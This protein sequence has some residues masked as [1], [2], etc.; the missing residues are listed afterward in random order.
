MATF[1]T[2]TNLI[3]GRL[4]EVQLTSSTFSSATGMQ[5][6]MQNAVNAAIY[7]ICRR[8]QQWPFIY[9]QQT[10]TTVIGTQSYTPP[11]NCQAIKWNTFGIVRN[12]NASPPIVAATL[13]EMDYNLWATRRRFLD[14]QLT[15]TNYSTPTNVIKG[16]DGSI[17]LSPPPKQVMNITYDAWA[18]PTG[19]VN[20]NDSCVIPDS[21]N[22]IITDGA[23]W[24]GYDFRGDKA[25]KDDAENKFNSGVKEMQRLLIKPTNAFQS[26]MVVNNRTFNAIPSRFGL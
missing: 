8:E 4:N 24:Y 6:N 26:T 19:L 2:L 22:Y 25:A 20:Y 12:D 3:L 5:L 21:F 17:I 10:L 13:T 9:S 23:M 1:L 11:S 14:Q 15:S 16:D 7:D 18:T